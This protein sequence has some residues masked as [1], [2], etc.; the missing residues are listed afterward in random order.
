MLIVFF[1]SVYMKLHKDR[2]IVH[3]A[4]DF[5]GSG[6]NIGMRDFPLGP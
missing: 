5:K 4:T 6:L 2:C 1:C 3:D